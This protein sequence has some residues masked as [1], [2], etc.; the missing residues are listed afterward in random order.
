M[1]TQR[2]KELFTEKFF[3]ETKKILFL[4]LK[5]F[6][7]IN[8]LPW[9]FFI[10]P[11]I[12]IENLYFLSVLV[13]SK[14]ENCVRNHLQSASRLPSTAGLCT[15]GWLMASATR[16]LDLISSTTHHEHNTSQIVLSTIHSS[17]YQMTI[18]TRWVIV[19]YLTLCQ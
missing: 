3:G 4:K 1:F 15:L 9:M 16:L 12:P 19:S 10:E 17:M 6:L 11:C 18:A 14:T 7:C 2:K 13:K 5:V 8:F